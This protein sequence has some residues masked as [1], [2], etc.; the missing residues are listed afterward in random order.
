MSYLFSF[1]P[2]PPPK[3][4]RPLFATETTCVVY[5][6]LFNNTLRRKSPNYEEASI[7]TKKIRITSSIRQAAFP[8]VFVEFSRLFSLKKYFSS[9]HVESWSIMPKLICVLRLIIVQ[10]LIWQGNF[11][12]FLLDRNNIEL[13]A[14]EYILV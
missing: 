12:P 6:L 10:V 13:S 5:F 9:A 1:F 11:V 7:T 3:T 2:S 8:L 14:Y 4:Y